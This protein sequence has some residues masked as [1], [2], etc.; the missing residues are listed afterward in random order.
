E[1]AAPH[2][3][4]TLHRPGKT[5]RRRPAS[6][7]WHPLGTLPPRATVAYSAVR[8]ERGD[9]TG[10]TTTRQGPFPHGGRGGGTA[11]G[12][13]HDG[14]PADQRRRPRRGPRRQVLPA[15]RG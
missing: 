1:R 6:P 4:H 14:L 7:P 12:V 11:A 15:P 5:P 2:G 8:A 3:D 10:T 9:S 13:Q